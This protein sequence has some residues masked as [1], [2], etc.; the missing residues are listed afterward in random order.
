MLAL[1]ATLPMWLVASGPGEP[2]PPGQPELGPGSA[3]YLHA[4]VEKSRHGSGGRAF[5]LFEPADPVPERAPLVVFLHGW[6]ATNPRLYGA[7]LDHLVRRGNVVVFPRWQTSALSLPGEFVPNARAA[8]RAALALE[9]DGGP[10]IDRERVAFIGHSMGGLIAANL[11]ASAAEDGL[12]R[13]A[14][15]FCVQPGLTESGPFAVLELEDLARIPADTLLVAL[16]SDQDTVVGSRDARRIVREASAVPEEN[17][18]L[19]L[20]RSDRHGLPFLVADHLA[21]FAY[22]ERFRP[23]ADYDAAP[24]RRHLDALDTWGLWRPFDALCAL[25]FADGERSAALGDAPERLTM[26]LW[27]DGTPVA[28]LRRLPVD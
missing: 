24:R 26:G 20:L 17:K 15:L 7:W 18:D 21:P 1:F 28:P 8:L 27:S 3:H 14:V 11:T 12:P 19:L 2:L 25:A 10:T 6:L 23:G 5:W 16:A 22:D 9:R 13:P 4:R